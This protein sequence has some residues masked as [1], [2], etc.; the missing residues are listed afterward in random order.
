MR[1][2]RDGPMRASAHIG[3]LYLVSCSACGGG[4]GLP[5]AGT[6]APFDADA[7]VDGDVSRDADVTLPDGDV[8]PADAGPEPIWD[9]TPTVVGVGDAVSVGVT[10][11]VYPYAVLPAGDRVYVVGEARSDFRWGGDTIPDGGFVIA[12]DAVSGALI[13]HVDFGR[14]ST[15]NDIDRVGP[16]LVIAG[17]FTRPTTLDSIDGDPIELVSAGASDGFVARLTAEGGILWATSFGAA[18]YD[19]AFG[20]HASGRGILVAGSLRG[21]WT[22]CGG[23]L[24]GFP[25]T[26]DPMEGRPLGVEDAILLSLDDTGN[27]VDASVIGNAGTDEFALH[28]T[29]TADSV[30]L[31]GEGGGSLTRRWV[32]GTEEALGARAGGWLLELRDDGEHEVW[33]VGGR[34]A[35]GRG[36]ALDD[37]R[38]FFSFTTGAGELFR[39]DEIIGTV[40]DGVSVLELSRIDGSTEIH[41]LGP[42][43]TD[44]FD[45]ALANQGAVVPAI[46]SDSRPHT[47]IALIGDGGIASFRNDASTSFPYVAEADGDSVWLA[48]WAGS[49]PAR[50]GADEIEIPVGSDGGMFLVRFNL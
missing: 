13:F 32:D 40:E 7:S 4:A 36:I 20:V 18:M 28:V 34:G 50:I 17:S 24:R 35:R 42:Y 27:C 5:D 49:T 23:T 45:V 31:T 8:P 48:G 46:G 21:D 14:G 29:T 3:T 12:V 6:D 9:A 16:D 25:G 44:T 19:I 41:W 10:L 30:L 22:G 1:A 2:Q 47:R 26:I 37:S 11:P 38:L 39:G 15:V 33:S 43:T